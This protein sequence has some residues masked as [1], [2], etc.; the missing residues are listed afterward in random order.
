MTDSESTPSWRVALKDENH[1]LYRAAWVL[2]S[3]SYKVE[4]AAKRLER[5]R[6][7]LAP[8]FIE[9]IETEEL[10]YT[11]APGQGKAPAR[12]IELAGHLKLTDV[13]PTIVNVLC[14][15]EHFDNYS[16][17]Y[18]AATQNT[19]RYGEIIIAPILERVR[20]V[21]THSE[22][23][24]N[25][26]GAAMSALMAATRAVPGNDDVFQALQAVYEHADRDDFNTLEYMSR[27]MME[28]DPDRAKPYLN[29]SIRQ[30]KIKGENRKAIEGNIKYY[31][32][33]RNL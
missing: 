13:I 33:M 25:A 3:Q 21:M 18:Y 29:A 24:T 4:K 31:Q 10:W 6:D 32:S 26:H 19:P 9:V 5:D 14:D 2:F 20:E 15:P 27:C 22:P 12:A 11:D 23:G 17:V 7:L 8:F 1:P 28:C 16:D 30:R